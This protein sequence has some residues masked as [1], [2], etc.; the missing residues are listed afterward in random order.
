MGL[1]PTQG[2]EKRLLPR[3]LSHGSVAL[4]FV[5]STEAKRS[6]EISVLTPLPGDVFR[7][8]ESWT[9]GPPKVMKNVFCPRPLSHGSV[10]LTFVI[11]T[12]AKRSGEISVLTP[13]PG[14]VFRPEE[15]WACGPPKVMKNVFCPRPLSHGSVALTF[16]ISTEAKRSGEISV[17]TPLPGDVFRQSA[18]QWRNPRFLFGSHAAREPQSNVVGHE[19]IRAG[20]KLCRAKP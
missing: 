17:L 7:P 10:A 12:E 13:L 16:V 5:I 14:D 20:P 1:R 3:P 6:G 8:E 19:G 15:S 18:A 9:C 11:S 4:T 2:D